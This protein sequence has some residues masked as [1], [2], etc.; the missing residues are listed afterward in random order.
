MPI[1]TYNEEY[2]KNSKNL[3]VPQ[4]S[5]IV[6]HCQNQYDND[7]S[8]DFRLFLVFHQNTHRTSQHMII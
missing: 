6:A 4:K 7:L 5:E 1:I 3:E 8:K 2:N